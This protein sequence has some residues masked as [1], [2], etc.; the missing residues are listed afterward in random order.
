MLTRTIAFAAGAKLCLGTIIVLIPTKEGIIIASDSRSTASNKLF[1][2]SRTKIIA[3]P[4]MHREPTAFGTSGLTEIVVPGTDLSA[5]KGIC[6]ALQQSPKA[7]DV[8]KET[9]TYLLAHSL[10]SLGDVKHLAAALVE[11]V[12]RFRRAYPK[13]TQGV[14]PGKNLFDVRLAMYKRDRHKFVMADCAVAMSADGRPMPKTTT[15][16]EYDENSAPLL[17]LEGDAAF[18]SKFVLNDGSKL[19]RRWKAMPSN[20]LSASQGATEARIAIEAAYAAVRAHSTDW[21]I[22]GPIQVYLVSSTGA[23]PMQ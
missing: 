19:S 1:C 15:W 8:Q 23:R 12:N 16:D 20:P 11:T 4:I 17:S 10:D 22:G 9:E 2:N 5:Y 3:L 6:D 18:L 7:L 14:E 13:E 21:G